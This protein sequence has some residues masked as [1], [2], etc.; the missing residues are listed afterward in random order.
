VTKLAKLSMVTA[1]LSA[2][3]M[4]GCCS[5]PATEE[6]KLIAIPLMRQAT[7]HTCGVASLQAILAYY[8][9]DC[10]EDVLAQKLKADQYASIDEIERYMTG[11]GFKVNRHYEMSL[12]QLK[13]CI[14]RGQ[15]LM[16][17]VQAWEPEGTTLEQYQN[18]YDAGHWVVVVGYDDQNIYMMDPSTPGNYAFVPTAEFMVRWHDRDDRQ[19]LL[20][21]GMTF[22]S[23]QAPVYRRDEFKKMQ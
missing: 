13:D 19:T 10:R 15:P 11:L 21:Y 6:P 2:F 3:V 12:A 16:V 5:K 17:C 9:I 22:E 8:G 20:R 1:L 4:T 18:S 7:D 23:P 14:D